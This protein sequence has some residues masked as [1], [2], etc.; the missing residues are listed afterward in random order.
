MLARGAL[1]RLAQRQLEPTPENFARAYADESGQAAGAAD[2]RPGRAA[3]AAWMPLVA[4]LDST[5]RAAL[6]GDDPRSAELARRFAALAS[7]LAADGPSAERQAELVQ[8]EQQ[9]RRHFAHRQD[10]LVELGA[11]CGELTQGLT[12]LAEDESWARGQCAGVQ[13][14]LGEGLNAR[15]VR[16]AKEL[17]AATRLRQQEVRTER[18]SAREGLR[19]LIQSMLTEIR[20]LG[21][22]TGRLQEVTEQHAGALD[23]VDTIE[24]L[25][26]LV[27]AMIADSRAMHGAVSRSQERLQADSARA[28]DLEARVRPRRRR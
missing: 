28:S 14:R 24:G 26:G 15:G 8:L 11:L 2:A 25:T 20:E 19:R 7:A 13:A 5:V 10:L 23:G 6:P 3:A 18:Q 1:R 27:Q 12:E 4:L 17:L 9:A 16:A 22:Q 21:E